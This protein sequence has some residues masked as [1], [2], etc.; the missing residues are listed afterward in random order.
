MPDPED[1]Q[2]L[3]DIRAEQAKIDRDIATSRGF[4]R[5]GFIR[6]RRLFDLFERWAI[7]NIRADEGRD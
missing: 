1:W 5:W 2:M 3:Q 7:S 6:L 4:F